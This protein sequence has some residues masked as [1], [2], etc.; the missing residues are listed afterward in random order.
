MKILSRYI[1]ITFLKYWAICTLAMLFLVIAANLFG[2]IDAV[3]TSTRKLVEFF[4]ETVRSIPVI[5]DIALPITVLLATMFTFSA[6]A[7]TSELVAMRSI[8]MG[9]SRQ[10]APILIVVVF[11]SALDYFNQNYLFRFLDATP[12]RS[13]KL[14]TSHAWKARQDRIFYLSNV[15]SALRDVTGI[16]IFRWASQPFRVVEMENIRRISQP[17][18]GQ[19]VYEDVVSRKFSGNEWRLSRIARL[20]KPEREFPNVFLQDTL[21]AH[22]MPIIDLY[23]KIRQRESLGEKVELYNLEWYQKTAAIFAP[24]VL[25]W[26]GTPLSQ[27]YFRQG[28]ASGEILLGILGCLIFLV[29]TEI[30]FLFGKGGFLPPSVSAWTI[31]LV[32]LA[33]GGYL[34]RRAR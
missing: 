17:N 33:L 5:L 3:F 18:D 22:Y 4:G 12:G 30:F 24:F 10:L 13:A 16:R 8:G 26:F 1:A 29:A 7:R 25:V 34:M 14:E 20:E 32:F 21:D 9:L 6:L 27:S 31:N 2:H 28:R 19:W 23:R 11:I 15:D